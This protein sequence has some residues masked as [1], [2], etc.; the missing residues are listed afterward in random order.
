MLQPNSNIYQSLLN[1]A[2]LQPD[3]IAIVFEDQSW[4][5]DQLLK[6]VNQTMRW[7]SSTLRLQKGDRIVLGWGNTIEFCQLFYA[8][9]GLGIQ[10]IPLSTKMKEFEGKGHLSCINA[11]AIFWDDSCQPWL[12]QFNTRGI[13][14]SQWQSLILSDEIEFTNHVNEDDPAVII[15]TSGTTGTPKGAVIT[16]KN[17]LSAIYAYQETLKLSAIDKTILSVPIYHITGL[18]AILA[19]FIHIGG[20]V[21][22]HRKFNAKDIFSTIAKEKI[23]FLHGSP[24]VFILLIKK[25]KENKSINLERFHSLRM[26]ACGAGH[27]NEG[28]IKELSYIFSETSIHSIYG[29][30]ETSSPAT[31]YLDDIRSGNKKA[32]SGLPVPGLKIAIRN[33]IGEDKPANSTGNIWV[34]GDVVINRY[35]PD[36]PANETAFKAGWFFTGDIGYVDDDG[37]LYIQDRIKDMINR[38]GE[39]IYSIEIEDLISNYPGVNEV[40]VIPIES[41]IY[42]EEPIAFIIPES[43]FCL[44][45]K[46][47]IEWLKDRVPTYKVPVRIMFTRDFPRTWNGKISKKDLKKRYYDLNN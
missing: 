47:I 39:K 6:K 15:F 3:A 41:A 37:Y 27:L 36:S 17:I 44:T 19:L 34:K 45:S 38:G 24:T 42:G 13:S 4:R 22:L 2:K 5:Y 40:A 18:S 28:T 35:W 23:T 30:T 33:D 1:R 16:H 14:L 8:A 29:L 21:Y 10:V 12:S 46:E 26:I 7:L 31:V 9:V 25:I 32:S 43:Q 20:T 11:D